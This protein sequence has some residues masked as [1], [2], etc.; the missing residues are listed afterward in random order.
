MDKSALYQPF[1]FGPQLSPTMSLGLRTARVA[2]LGWFASAFAH[3]LSRGFRP[4]VSR[5][6]ETGQ[7]VERIATLGIALI[8]ISLIAREMVIEAGGRSGVA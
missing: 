3:R 1:A 7:E 4:D 6:V 5:N 2:V 8:T